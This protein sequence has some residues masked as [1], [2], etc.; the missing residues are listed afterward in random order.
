MMCHVEGTLTTFP[1]TL[2]F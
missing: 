1:L 2:F